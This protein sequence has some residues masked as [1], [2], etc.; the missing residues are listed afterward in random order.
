MTTLRPPVTERDQQTGNLESKLTLVEYGDYQCPYCR[1]AHAFTNRLLDEHGT[2]IRFVFR[3]FPLQEIHAQAFMAALS[4][5]AAG[6][7]GRFWDMHGLLFDNQEKFRQ[8]TIFLDLADELQLDLAQFVT[9][10]KRSELINKVEKD[11]GGGIYSGV[12]RTP[13]FFINESKVFT[14]D[15][16]YESLV[17]SIEL[18]V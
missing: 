4:A 18:L 2:E 3:H 7:Q 16:S 13:T 9:D 5:E 14:Y 12:S 8:K 17:S 11:F 6:T 15:G 1:R 10:R